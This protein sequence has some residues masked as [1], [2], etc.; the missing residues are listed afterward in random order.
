MAA[1]ASRRL[2]FALWPSD[3][4]SRRLHDAARAAH[5]AC[6]GRLMRRETLHITLAFLGNVPESRMSAAEA[7]AATVAGESFEF[8]LDRLACWK[9]NHILWAGCSVVPAALSGLADDLAQGLRQAGFMLE[10]RP[11]VVHATLLRNA[12]C[13]QTPPTLAAPIR[14][15]V[16]NFALVESRRGET[17]SR[18]EVLRRW[19]LAASID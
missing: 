18:Y 8:G 4:V 17:G 13:A 9:R 16:D 2:F 7:A 10:E 14:W 1:D 6:G 3:A 11:F 5:P 19:P 12:E 15:P